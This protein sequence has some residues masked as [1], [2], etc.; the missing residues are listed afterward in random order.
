[1]NKNADESEQSTVKSNPCDQKKDESAPKF[2]SKT[3]SFLGLN[4]K[5]DS[6]ESA[7]K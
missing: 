1:M 3:S 6:P 7:L 5:A 2:S 4:F